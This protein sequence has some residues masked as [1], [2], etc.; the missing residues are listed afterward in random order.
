MQITIG[1]L[2]TSS[3]HPETWHKY[4]TQ[5]VQCAHSKS[6]CVIT[7]ITLNNPKTTLVDFKTLTACA[8]ILDLHK[9][10]PQV[11]LA[12]V[13]RPCHV[14]QCP[15]SHVVLQGPGAGMHEMECTD[16]LPIAEDLKTV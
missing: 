13:S 11:R 14:G 4:Q 5:V 1:T 7:W 12:L 15:L 3:D 16:R 9:Q 6:E 2:S 10:L 8:D